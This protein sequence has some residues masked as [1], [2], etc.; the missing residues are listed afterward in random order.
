MILMLTNMITSSPCDH[1]LVNK[2]H[3]YLQN[4]LTF[5][6]SYNEDTDPLAKYSTYDIISKA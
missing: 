4:G 6:N 3:I 2:V 1:L 5:L